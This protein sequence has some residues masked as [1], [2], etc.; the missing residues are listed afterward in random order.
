MIFNTVRLQTA[1]QVPSTGIGAKDRFPDANAESIQGQIIIQNG[2]LVNNG[3]SILHHGHYLCGRWRERSEGHTIKSTEIDYHREAQLGGDIHGESVI[4]NGRSLCLTG[5]WS[6]NFYHWLLQYLPILKIAGE[7]IPLDEVDNVLVKGPIKR[8]QSES[9][10]LLGIPPQKIIGISPGRNYWAEELVMTTIPCA[11]RTYTQWAI[12]FLRQ[13]R[14]PPTTP[15]S[16]IFF[17]RP[18]PAS[19]RMVNAE[20]VYSVLADYGI[21]CIDCGS[22]S[23]SDQVRL[24]SS[25]NL[26]LGIHGA[27]LANAVFSAPGTTL[28]ELTPRNYSPPYFSGLAKACQLNYAR[29]LGREPGLLSPWVPIKGAD[30]IVPIDSLRS[31]LDRFFSNQG[32]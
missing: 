7:C 10:S 30:I 2:V 26:L 9:L 5:P 3:D 18:F 21:P 27:S 19:R 11:N 22:F 16:P 17:D 25:A 13:L 29:I 1:N 15:S 20:E 6:E 24:A 8:F 14:E 31:K 12:D 28:I 32:A 23:F 4:I